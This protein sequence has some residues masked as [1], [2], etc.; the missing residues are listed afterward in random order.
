MARKQRSSDQLSSAE[1]GM[2]VTPG[3]QS[4]EK[5]YEEAR[6]RRIAGVGDAGTGTS[7]VLVTGTS[8]AAAGSV[9]G[10]ID[11]ERRKR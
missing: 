4:D 6:E 2:N 7:D 9:T 1:R 11:D 8:E 3:D 10:E 5:V